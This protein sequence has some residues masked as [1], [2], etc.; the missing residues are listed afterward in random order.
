MAGSVGEH[1]GIAHSCKASL[2]FTLAPVP[3]QQPAGPHSPGPRDLHTSPQPQRDEANSLHATARHGSLETR[4]QPTPPL[5]PG[6]D[7][8]APP[9]RPTRDQTPLG[10]RAA[11]PRARS[12]R[13]R[14]DA[15][16]RPG[17]ARNWNLGPAL[18]ELSVSPG[19]EHAPVS[20]SRRFCSVAASGS[21]WGLRPRQAP[22]NRRRSNAGDVLS[23]G[24]AW[25]GQRGGLQQRAE[26]ES[27]APPAGHY[28]DEGRASQRP[29][30]DSVPASLTGLN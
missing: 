16:L 7:P 13:R 21:F 28:E 6:G 24:S 22:P 14:R 18:Q 5:C 10:T 1:L 3:L 30:P 23:N 9:H 2:P 12:S 29:S 8:A 15:A 20:V 17:P 26:P 19:S 11:R 25:L 27:L 4:H